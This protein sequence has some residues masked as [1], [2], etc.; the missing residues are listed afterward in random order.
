MADQGPHTISL[1]QERLQRLAGGILQRLNAC[2]DAIAENILEHV[3][4]PLG[5]IEFR[6]VRRKGQHMDALR[7]TGIARAKME[8]RGRRQ[9]HFRT[10]D[11]YTS[12]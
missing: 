10:D 9:L 1:L 8:S 5:R 4:E 2:V 6:T 11:N 7:Q 3:P 12:A